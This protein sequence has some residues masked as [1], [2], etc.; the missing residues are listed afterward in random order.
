M[1]DIA[2]LLVLLAVAGAVLTLL[3]GVVIW[4][5]DEGR[6]IRRGLKVMLRGDTH[7]LLVARGRG[8]GVSPVELEVV[9]VMS[10]PSGDHLRGL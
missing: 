4:S 2:R 6:R 5:M 9:A 3:G 1:D 8:R 7:G 10:S